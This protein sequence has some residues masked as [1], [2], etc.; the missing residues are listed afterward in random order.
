VAFC[1]CLLQA[2]QRTALF[3]QERIYAAY[4]GKTPS[5]RR[6]R[7]P[8]SPPIGRDDYLCPLGSYRR[9][10]LHGRSPGGPILSHNAGGPCPAAL[11]RPGPVYIVKGAWLARAVCNPGR[12]RLLP[13][14]R[15]VYLL[16]AGGPAGRTHRYD[17]YTRIGILRRAAGHGF[18]RGSR[19]GNRSTP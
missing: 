14:R 6:Y 17:P 7:L 13:H 9:I 18:I 15:S 12:A 11:G 19:H 10:T 3:Y 4:Q 8:D 16:R 1:R 5:L 2:E